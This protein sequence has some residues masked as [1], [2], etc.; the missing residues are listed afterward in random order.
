MAEII[1]WMEPALDGGRM[2]EL[3]DVLDALEHFPG[4]G[5]FP[6]VDRVFEEAPYSYARIRAVALMRLSDPEFGDRRADECLWDGEERIRELGA[7]A[8]DD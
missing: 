2:L 3:C 4:L 1:G 8:Q 6:G 5:P 7:E